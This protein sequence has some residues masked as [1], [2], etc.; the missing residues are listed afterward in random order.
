VV[1]VVAL[2]EECLES[3]AFPLVAFVVHHHLHLWEVVVAHL[4]SVV[5]VA[6]FASPLIS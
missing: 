3:V 5:V 1:A 4:L 2:A 6:H